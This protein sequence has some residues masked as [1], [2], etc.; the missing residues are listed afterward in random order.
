MA[1]P[2][3]LIVDTQLPSREVVAVV[4]EHADQVRF[5]E[6]VVRTQLLVAAIVARGVSD[7][8]ATSLATSPAKGSGAVLEIIDEVYDQDRFLPACLGLVDAIA[9][10]L[11]ATRVSVGWIQGTA[12]RTFAVSG[13]E[14]FERNTDAIRDLERVL[15]ESIDH[16][17][18][19]EV[20]AAIPAT[21]G[22]TH[23]HASYAKMKSLSQLVSVPIALHGEPRGA[24]VIEM[25]EGA[26]DQAALVRIEVT[27]HLVA[28]WL[29]VLHRRERAW[30]V[31]LQDWARDMSTGWLGPR[32]TLAKLLAVSLATF[33]ILASVIRIPFEV[34]ATATL[35]TDQVSYLTAPF[36]GF[37]AA[38]ASEAGE[39][40]QAGQPV[41]SLD[42]EELEL[43]QLEESA[44]L[45]RFQSE[46]EKARSARNLVDM[47]VALARV[48]QAETELERTRYY[49]DRS[50]LVAAFD[51]I[52]V[53]GERRELLG[54]PVAQ[55]DVLMKIADP[56][57]LFVRIKLNE[58][59][60]DFVAPG[61]VG[62]LRLLSMPDEVHP[63]AVTRVVPAA[64]VD[65]AEGNVFVVRARLV[66]GQEEWWRPG[67]SGAVKLE[68]GSRPILAVW[69]HRTWEAIRMWLWL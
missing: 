65:Q 50:T 69:L 3:L 31:K 42:S 23:A 52:V 15:E 51:G 2:F 44:N 28:H 57:R 25:G 14:N 39:T 16:E 66:D 19:V 20:G 24:V 60:I 8:G 45:Q 59:D 26:L 27:L 30:W 32:H 17:S 47:K 5:N 22:L 36:N 11:G 46:V 68:A 34:D 9:V 61:S 48:K 41:I 10:N 18:R 7:S 62:G 55:G 63:V 4:T 53:E 64:V 12:V 1:Q 33:L 37:V 49:L 58:R 29:E 54:S 56:A 40:V 38:I 6:V 13:L 43:R 21:P 67:M 35:E